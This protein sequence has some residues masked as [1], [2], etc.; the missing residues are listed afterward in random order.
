LSAKKKIIR[1]KERYLATVKNVRRS[2]WKIHLADQ[3][4]KDRAGKRV[5]PAFLNYS[6]LC[7]AFLSA[8]RL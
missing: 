7:R 3:A 1:F 8:V 4:E 6:V 2:S 5:W